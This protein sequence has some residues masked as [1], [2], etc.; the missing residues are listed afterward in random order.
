MYT[1][2]HVCSC[3]LQYFIGNVLNSAEE[4]P[5]GL[6]HEQGGDSS[7]SSNSDNSNGNNSMT[8]AKAEASATSSSR[9]ISRSEALLF[10]TLTPLIL[11]S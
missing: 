8:G 10:L 5:A 6:Q 2:I 4:K 9:L 1:H 11:K 3:A 7:S